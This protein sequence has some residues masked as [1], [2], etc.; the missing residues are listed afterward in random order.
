MYNV[1]TTQTTCIELNTLTC[2]KAYDIRGKLGTELKSPIKLAAH[3]DKSINQRRR[4]WY[5]SKQWGFKTSDYPND[6]GVNVLDL[7]M[8]GTEEVLL[9]I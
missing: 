3:T 1:H 6:A 5:S 8:T 4:L 7:G 9:F 2:F